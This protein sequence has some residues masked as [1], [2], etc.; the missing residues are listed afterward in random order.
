MDRIS[1]Y[2]SIMQQVLQDY[3]Q[4]YQRS[5]NPNF[6]T[7]LLCDES[8][9]QYLLMRLGWE[10]DRR[11]NHTVIHLRLRDGKIWIEE[12]NTEDGVAT[13]LLAAGVPHE[14][15]VLAFHPP[16]LRQ[17]TEFAIV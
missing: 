2:R 11:V 16:R 10:G 1:E 8:Q 13:D 12:D 6:E 14:A 3:Y 5:E 17:H 15:I 4:L 7:M 9:A